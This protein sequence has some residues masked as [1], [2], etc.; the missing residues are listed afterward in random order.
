MSRIIAIVGALLLAFGIIAGT[1]LD[2]SPARPVEHRAGYRVV[3]GDFHAHTRFSD[4]VV[5][6]CDLV[7]QARRR[8]LDV[9]GVTE[10]NTVFPGQIARACTALVSD[11]P[12]V[13][14]GE[15]VTT[16]ELHMLALGIEKDVDAR[17]PPREVVAAVHAQGGVV[18]AAHPTKRFWP[19]LTP[20]CDVV[21]GIEVVHPIAYRDSD[22]G[23]GRWS[24]IVELAKGECGTDKAMIGNSDYHAGS[25]LGIT[26]TYLFVDQL[27][28]A[29]VTSAIREGRTVTRA[30]DGTMFGP[31]ALVASLQDKPLADRPADY[32]YA[33]T[34]V[35]DRVAR[36]LGLIGAL[37]LCL[38]RVSG[39]RRPNEA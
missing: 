3:Q 19:A 1:L 15:E 10:H 24:E 32:G 26:R 39:P 14:V 16:R 23:I 11:A 13:V 25:V 2:T 36:A 33:G 27:S 6:P 21:D 5:S 22:G 37:L 35:L 38:V 17:M 9:I 20:I 7:L 18:V 28:A 34:G 12:V 8:G 4:G 29:G 30:P 31:D